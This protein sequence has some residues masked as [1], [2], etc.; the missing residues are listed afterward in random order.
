MS[1]APTSSTL[2]PPAFPG[3][4]DWHAHVLL[5]S[6]V[7]VYVTGPSMFCSSVRRSLTAAATAAM[8][9]RARVSICS[10]FSFDSVKICV[11]QQ[12]SLTGSTSCSNGGISKVQRAGG[13]TLAKAVGL[14][15]PISKP[16]QL[17]PKC[18]YYCLRELRGGGRPLSAVK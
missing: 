1:G 11:Q 8:A 3:V 14:I 18:C 13:R 12:I 6:G 5:G 7:F 2:R 15:V 9:S 17:H 16:T 10:T 4:T